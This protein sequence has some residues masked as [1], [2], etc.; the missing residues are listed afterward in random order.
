MTTE[1]QT[2]EIGAALDY[3]DACTTGLPAYVET[4]AAAYGHGRVARGQ[5]TLLLLLI[6]D[7]ARNSD[8]TPRDIIARMREEYGGMT[9]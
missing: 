5:S 2:A 6:A 7:A 4:V 9:A 8:A 1:Q 3:L